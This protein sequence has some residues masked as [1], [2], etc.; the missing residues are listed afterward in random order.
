M[1]HEGPVLSVFLFRPV[2]VSSYWKL[3]VESPQS[4]LRVKFMVLE[5]FISIGL[6]FLLGFAIISIYA[7]IRTS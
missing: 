1:C 3:I 2:L 7:L 5:D 6:N 4:L